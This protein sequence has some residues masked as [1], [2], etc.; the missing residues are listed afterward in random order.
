MFSYIVD[1]YVVYN[2]NTKQPVAHLIY[3]PRLT[4][5]IFCCCYIPT[6]QI[7]ANFSRMCECQCLSESEENVLTSNII[8]EVTRKLFSHKMENCCYCVV[9]A[10]A[11]VCIVRL[12]KNK[13]YLFIPYLFACAER[14]LAI[15]GTDLI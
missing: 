5:H 10:R 14:I 15:K 9:Y 11:S 7:Y 1:T 8:A 13:P 6:W 4:E 3:F 2:K 12:H